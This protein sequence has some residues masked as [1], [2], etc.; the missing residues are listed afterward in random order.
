MRY[1][2]YHNPTIEVMDML[3]GFPE[4]APIYGE[5]GE[6]EDDDDHTSRGEDHDVDLPRRGGRGLA[7][8]VTLG[9]PW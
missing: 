7:C 4:G 5:H 3:R 9:E 8:K 6:E 2:T 1:E